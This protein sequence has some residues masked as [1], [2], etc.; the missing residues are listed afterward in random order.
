MVHKTA[1]AVTE[2]WMV[3]DSFFFTKKKKK[4]KG[5]SKKIKHLATSTWSV[6]NHS[7]HLLKLLEV[8]SQKIVGISVM[9]NQGML[10]QMIR[11]SLEI[12]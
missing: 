5:L 11:N 10:A 12:H 8:L 3:S 2:I 9:E 1:V 4:G 7:L 6:Q